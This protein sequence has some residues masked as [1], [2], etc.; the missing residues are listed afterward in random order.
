[1]SG[2]D[3]GVANGESHVAKPGLLDFA[4]IS[5]DDLS[6]LD[7]SIVAAVIRDLVRHHRGGPQGG[8]RFCNFEASI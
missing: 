1:M 8:E 7:D 3:A 5:F 6:R 4:G 2:H